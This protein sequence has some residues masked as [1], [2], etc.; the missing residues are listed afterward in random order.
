MIATITIVAVSRP[1][2]DVAS[3]DNLMSLMRF[4]AL[5]MIKM[6]VAIKTIMRA[7]AST[8]PFIMLINAAKPMISRPSPPNKANIP[9]TLVIVSPNVSQSANAAAAFLMPKDRIRMLAA[10]PSIGLISPLIFLNSALENFLVA[11]AIHMDNLTNTAISAP[12][13]TTALHIFPAGNKD[14]II[15]D[16]AKATMAAVI[17][18]TLAWNVFPNLPAKNLLRL[19]K[20]V[21]IVSAAF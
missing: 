16:A 17:A 10:I 2:I 13:A 7:D 4:N 18:L 12:I 1:S 15:T 14:R 11:W 6:A 21:L 9:I 8:L 5:A 3:S 19:L 20:V